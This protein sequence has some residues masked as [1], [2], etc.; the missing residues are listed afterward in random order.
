MLLPL[1]AIGVIRL[2]NMNKPV[3]KPILLPLTLQVTAPYECTHEH[4]CRRHLM[5]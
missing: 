2:S 5:H 4:H 3:S 1:H